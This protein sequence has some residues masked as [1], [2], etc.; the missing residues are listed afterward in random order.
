M[1]SKI[2]ISCN[3]PYACLDCPYPDCQNKDNPNKAEFAILRGAH[4]GW[5]HEAEEHIVIRMYGQGYSAQDISA[6]MNI[7]EKR[8][9]TIYSRVYSRTHSQHKKAASLLAQQSDR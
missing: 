1:N 3:P 8:V 4:G 7:P 5:E 6:V 9:R 2:K